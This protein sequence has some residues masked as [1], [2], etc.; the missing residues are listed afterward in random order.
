MALLIANAVAAAASFI[1]KWRLWR[2]TS[3]TQ[4]RE[5]LRLV[6][7]SVNGTSD[8]AGSL[9]PWGFTEREWG[10][11]QD[12]V[13]SVSVTRASESTGF[14]SNSPD[15]T[16]MLAVSLQAFPQMW[17]IVCFKSPKHFHSGRFSRACQARRAASVVGVD[18]PKTAI[19]IWTASAARN[20]ASL[21]FPF[22]ASSRARM[23]SALTASW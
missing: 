21:C 1:S 18:S 8:H 12:R 20:L 11:L 6:G 15:Q 14:A 5:A 3:V 23:S 19:A 4:Q 22:F 10:F 2:G 7:R 16:L 17:L 13:S 9:A